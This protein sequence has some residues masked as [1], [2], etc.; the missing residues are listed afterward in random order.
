MTFIF[1]V[2]M[3]YKNY[4]N[5]LKKNERKNIL[6]SIKILNN[7]ILKIKNKQSIGHKTQTTQKIRL[8]V[9]NKSKHWQKMC[10]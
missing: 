9:N 5:H 4:D 3:M 2:N 10:L 6:F 1:F 8:I 7:R